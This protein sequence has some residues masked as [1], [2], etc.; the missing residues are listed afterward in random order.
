MKSID[1]EQLAKLKERIYRLCDKIDR[2]RVGEAL[3]EEEI[4]AIEQRLNIRF[5]ETY[6]QI[7]LHVCSGLSD[8]EDYGIRTLQ[9]ELHYAADAKLTH[10]FS[11]ECP[12]RQGD[13]YHYMGKRRHYIEYGIHGGQDLNKHST[14]IG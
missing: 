6:R 4:Q 7:L 11:Q 14:T 2:L 13:A 12:L 1:A 8:H 10:L 3:S 5:P 9:Q